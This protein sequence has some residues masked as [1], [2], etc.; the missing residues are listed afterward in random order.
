MYILI[1]NRRKKITTVP[2]TV[3]AE[4]FRGER[5]VKHTNPDKKS[6]MTIEKALASIGK[7]IE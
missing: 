5:Q 1:G 7:G 3:S 6:L 2:R 4:Y